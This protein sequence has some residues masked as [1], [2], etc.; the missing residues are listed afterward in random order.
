M[1]VRVRVC[2]CVHTTAWR[3]LADGALRAAVHVRTGRQH[4]LQSAR[5]PLQLC[6]RPGQ[7]R[8]HLLQASQSVHSTR[9]VGD[10]QPVRCRGLFINLL[11]F[12]SSFVLLLVSVRPSVRLDFRKC[13]ISGDPHHRTFDGFTHHFQGPYTYYLT[14]DYPPT[15]A[16]VPLP[17]LSVRGKNIRRGGNRRIS[18][19]DEVYVDVYGVSVRLLQRKVVLVSLSPPPPPHMLGVSCC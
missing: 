8:R 7:T 15:G 3:L 19:L 17:S 5:L 4:Q 11:C 18:F 10:T 13:S 2:V 12:F 14:K 9:Y 16:E 6:V 1:C